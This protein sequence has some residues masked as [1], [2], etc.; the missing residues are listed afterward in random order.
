MIFC[1]FIHL[2][3]C[4]WPMSH[5]IGTP[6][7]PKCYPLFDRDAMKH[8]H[9]M[10]TDMSAPI[11]IWEDDIIQCNT[12]CRCRVGV[13][14]RRV[15]NTGICLIRRVSVLHSI[16]V[17]MW[18][19]CHTESTSYMKNYYDACNLEILKECL[20]NYSHNLGMQQRS[21]YI[22]VFCKQQKTYLALS[23]YINSTFT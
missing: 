17:I 6:M 21:K 19:V 20:A 3:H 2:W 14:H 5:D 16:D 22:V 4:G 18:F 11:I 10:D 23:I 8:G 15:S 9:D 7:S 1:H 12:M 13:G